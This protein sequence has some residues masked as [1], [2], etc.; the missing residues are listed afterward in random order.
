[1]RLLDISRYWNL[2][3]LSISIG[4][5]MPALADDLAKAGTI[6]QEGFW[7]IFEQNFSEILESIQLFKLCV[8]A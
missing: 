2:W 1:M 7:H 5:A 3:I 8:M 4:K 6:M